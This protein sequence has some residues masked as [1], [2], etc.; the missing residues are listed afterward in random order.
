MSRNIAKFAV[1]HK[2]SAS[3]HNVD[4][5]WEKDRKVRQVA[6]EGGGKQANKFYFFCLEF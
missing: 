2:N 3:S 4:T 5:A 1:L 6:H